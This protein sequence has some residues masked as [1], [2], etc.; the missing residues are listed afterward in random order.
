MGQFW[1]LQSV[2]DLKL[3]DL[4]G[5]NSFKAICDD[6]NQIIISRRITNYWNNFNRYATFSRTSGLKLFVYLR[7]IT[8]ETFVK[9]F[10]SFRIVS[11][12][13]ELMFMFLGGSVIKR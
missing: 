3:L 9:V 12:F 8:C 10:L 6:L 1:A 4:M 11:A 7:I 2:F 13:T 5:S